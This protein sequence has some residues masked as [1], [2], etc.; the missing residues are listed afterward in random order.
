MTS[1]SV[2]EHHR[3]PATGMR[4]L[5]SVGGGPFAARRTVFREAN[6]PTL[7][8]SMRTPAFGIHGCEKSPPL[9]AVWLAELSVHTD[10]RRSDAARRRVRSR[11]VPSTLTSRAISMIDDRRLPACSLVSVEAWTGRQT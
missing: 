2:S 4:I 1:T 7:I 11:E 3:Q 10:D 9:P 8:L 5:L 6:S